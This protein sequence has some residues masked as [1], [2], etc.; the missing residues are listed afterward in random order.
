MRNVK[1]APSLLRSLL[2]ALIC[3]AVFTAYPGNAPDGNI[4]HAV[5]QSPFGSGG[6]E[7]APDTAYIAVTGNIFDEDT[8]AP[9]KGIEVFAHNSSTGFI[10]RSISD[11]DG[12]Y[13]FTGLPT[14]TYTL[15]AHGG[16]SGYISKFSGD[17]QL[18]PEMISVSETGTTGEIDFFLAFEPG[19]TGPSDLLRGITDDNGTYT[20]QGFPSGSFKTLVAPYSLGVDNGFNLD[21]PGRSFTVTAPEPCT[22]I[23]LELPNVGALSGS[24]APSGPGAGECVE[25]RIYGIDVDLNKEGICSDEEGN[26]TVSGLP[27]GDYGIYA[28]QY[29]SGCVWYYEGDNYTKKFH[30]EA[31]EV[32]TGVDLELGRCGH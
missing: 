20:I 8:G 32:T 15:A 11:A 21:G 5:P 27:T 4:A 26:F 31:Q 7:P 6:T 14:G 10:H 19:T 23:D 16:Y 30:V 3:L 2:T 24:A 9:I 22:G 12:A 1:G 25:I 13:A 17:D 28:V 29:S 18:D